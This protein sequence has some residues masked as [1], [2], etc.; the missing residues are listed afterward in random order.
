MEEKIE[1]TRSKI[2]EV[3]KKW[4]EDYLAHPDNY[5]DG[6]AE[7]IEERSESQTALFLEFFYDKK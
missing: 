6:F 2:F 5:K 3:F 1:I 7:T 4:N